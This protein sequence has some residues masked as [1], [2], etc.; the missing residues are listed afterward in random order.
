MKLNIRTTNT[1]T[2]KNKDKWILF[3]FGP[4]QQPLRRHEI[5]TRDLVLI[6]DALVNRNFETSYLVGYIIS[7]LNT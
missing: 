3:R 7:Y 6:A 1:K 2:V 4:T 5:R